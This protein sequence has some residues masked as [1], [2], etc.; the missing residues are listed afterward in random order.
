MHHDALVYLKQ[1]F[2]KL[3]LKKNEILYGIPPEKKDK[4]KLPFWNRE[5]G[6]SHSCLLGYP[7]VGSPRESTFGVVRK[8][9]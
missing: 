1:G 9:W 5:E 2:L 8:E 7:A 4:S 3:N 6:W